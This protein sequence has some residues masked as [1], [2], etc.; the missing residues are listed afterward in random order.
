MLSFDMVLLLHLIHVKGS[1]NLAA[2][3]RLLFACISYSVAHPNILSSSF[4]VGAIRQDVV[5]K[6]EKNVM[7]NDM[8][9]LLYHF[10]ILCI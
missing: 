3:T 6:H 10:S 7:G 2:N 4:S 9:N 8:Y 1:V 5:D